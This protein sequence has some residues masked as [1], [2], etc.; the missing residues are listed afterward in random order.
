MAKITT[1]RLYEIINMSDEDIIKNESGYEL[2]VKRLF[3]QRD[4]YNLFISTGIYFTEET[5]K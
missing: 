4:F 5:L 1:D 3:K 2:H